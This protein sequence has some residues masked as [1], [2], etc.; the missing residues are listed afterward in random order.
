[1]ASYFRSSSLIK[2]NSACSRCYVHSGHAWSHPYLFKLPSGVLIQ[3][4]VSSVS[5]Q[6]A[7]R[8]PDSEHG[9]I[10]ISSS[11]HQESWFRTWSHP[12]LFRIVSNSQKEV[13]LN[14]SSRVRIVSCEL[15]E[16][17]LNSIGHPI[18]INSR[19]PTYSV[20]PSKQEK[21]QRYL[22]SS[23]T[24]HFLNV[25]RIRSLQTESVIRAKNIS[26][27]QLIEVLLFSSISLLFMST[28]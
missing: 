2:L 3:N 16:L 21:L 27:I 18:V 24:E 19:W 7:I 8:S 4:M 14:T 5:L 23:V 1:M 11:C 9:L 10:R 22:Q 28:R 25:T 13:L 20:L 6:V 15:W 17:A 26:N 12:Y